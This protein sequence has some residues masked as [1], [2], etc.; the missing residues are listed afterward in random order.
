MKPNISEDRTPFL[1]TAAALLSQLPG[2]DDHMRADLLGA[3]LFDEPIIDRIPEIFGDLDFSRRQRSGPTSRQMDKA[4]RLAQ[5]WLE[6]KVF[7][8]PA[9]RLRSSGHI[10]PPA[11]IFFAW[12][13]PAIIDAPRTAILNSRKPRS[14]DPLARWLEVTVS[15]FDRNVDP[16]SVMITSLGNHH[17]NLISFLAA[18]TGRQ[19]IIVF[20]GPL[21]M[22]NNQRKMDTFLETYRPFLTPGRSLLLSPFTPGRTGPLR[23]GGI[24][25]DDVVLGLADML[26][27]VE[28]REGGNM[29]RLSTRALE[30]GHRTLVYRPKQFD[31]ATKGNETLLQHGAEP[32]DEPEIPF[33][34]LQ[35]DN[36][37]GPIKQ[38]D[39]F[40]PDV[41]DGEYLF[42]FT[43]SCPGPWPGQ[44]LFDYYRALVDRDRNSGHTA[45]DTL[46]RILI[47]GRLRGSDR[48]TRGPA[49][50]VSFTACGPAQLSELIKWRRA[51]IR[52]TMEPYGLAVPR[53]TLIEL[54]AEPVVYG[55]GSVWRRLPEDQRYRFQLH[56]PP[57][58]DWS[59]E[60]EWRLAGDLNLAD[61][62]LSNLRIIVP[63]PEEAEK[64]FSAFGL[65]VIPAVDF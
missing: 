39:P 61:V 62:G 32:L 55:D 21:P 47:E 27:A 49:K 50:A 5:T 45:F 24:R 12:G 8:I 26:L 51:L 57:K 41:Q 53:E 10:D 48:L 28:I 40:A 65:A 23:A 34:I 14:I 43:R 3:C 9:A 1:L 37:K 56:R 36:V 16:E 38:T 64:I 29:E 60:K 13:N 54:G 19:Q 42:H 25:R 44:E 7:L 11:P 18:R 2:I 22:M 33:Q 63:S 30:R 52:W 35:N 20:D 59:R 6:R 15:L 31:R 58:T 17:Y 46:I 4:L